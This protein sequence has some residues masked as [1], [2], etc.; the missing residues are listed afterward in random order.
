MEMGTRLLYSQFGKIKI[1][2][3]LRF[4]TSKGSK[5]I[6]SG[7]Q[8]EIDLW[9]VILLKCIIILSSHIFNKILTI[10]DSPHRVQ[11]IKEYLTVRQLESITEILI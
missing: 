8:F 4:D 11:D 6:N 9:S 2:D 3:P 10:L 7:S 5:S 1:T